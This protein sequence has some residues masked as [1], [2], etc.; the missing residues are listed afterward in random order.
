MRVVRQ[1]EN[2]RQIETR[3]RTSDNHDPK[4]LP[5]WI[6]EFE[7]QIEPQEG[8]SVRQI[9]EAAHNELRSPAALARFNGEKGQQGLTLSGSRHT[10]SP[11]QLVDD[12]N[13][14]II[15]EFQREDVY[16]PVKESEKL[17]TKAVRDKD[18]RITANGKLVFTVRNYYWPW[19]SIPSNAIT[20]Q[21]QP[22]DEDA[23]RAEWQDN[24]W[25]ECYVG[26]SQPASDATDTT[27][28]HRRAAHMVRETQGGYADLVCI[29]AMA[30]SFLQGAS[31]FLVSMAPLLII[32]EVYGDSSDGSEGGLSWTLACPLERIGV[33]YTD[34]SMSSA[35][36]GFT[37]ATGRRSLLALSSCEEQQKT[38]ML[39]NSFTVSASQIIFGV[40]C[41]GLGAI[42]LGH[43]TLNRLSFELVTSCA[44]ADGFCATTAATI[45]WVL[46]LLAGI[47]ISLTYLTMGAMVGMALGIGVA[48]PKVGCSPNISKRGAGLGFVAGATSGLVSGLLLSKAS[49]GV[50]VGVVVA[51]AAAVGEAMYFSHVMWNRF[52]AQV[53]LGFATGGLAT[54]VLASVIFSFAITMMS[55]DR[56]QPL[57]WPTIGAC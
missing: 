10:P 11:I 53:L 16:V 41:L 28:T 39:Q 14:L 56:F 15:P 37:D 29:S 55:N 48:G 54:G 31:D 13:G 25:R 49:I 22:V 24:G 20:G 7:A 23:K 45:V 5:Y 52:L 6:L 8:F 21:P 9:C 42:G 2:K 38:C 26:P 34:F 32:Y 27:S 57:L 47:P 46:F 17:E 35:F 1:Q 51:A 19:G 30:A 33:S 3:R 50:V 43:K 40:V 4:S 18:K 44:P 12:G 36:T